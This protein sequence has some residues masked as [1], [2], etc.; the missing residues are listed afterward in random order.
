MTISKHLFII[1]QRNIGKSTF[2][3]QLS[4]ELSLPVIH[5]DEEIIK[6]TGESINNYVQNH[7][8]AAF[9]LVESACLRA[10]IR[11]PRCI[12]D[13]GG[14][15]TDRKINWHIIIKFGEVIWLDAPQQDMINNLRYSKSD[16]QR[17]SW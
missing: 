3:K 8:W 7:S 17:P 13:T 12:I 4:K 1:G 11:R 2:A 9:R 6:K 15:I 14:G 5:L 10:A 16:Q